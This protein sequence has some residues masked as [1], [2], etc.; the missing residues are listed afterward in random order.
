MSEQGFW[1]VRFVIQG[2]RSVKIYVDSNFSCE[3]ERKI[4]R[5]ETAGDTSRP[6]GYERL[7]LPLY[8]VADTPFHIQRGDL[9]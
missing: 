4:A 2:L 3:K 9:F 8:K 5:L 6:L 1:S 7:Y